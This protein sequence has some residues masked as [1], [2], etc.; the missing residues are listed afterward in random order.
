MIGFILKRLLVMKQKGGAITHSEIGKL[1]DDAK[2]IYYSEFQIFD[3]VNKE[4]KVLGQHLENV[5]RILNQQELLEV[6]GDLSFFD[7]S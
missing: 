4:L 1:A 6:E 5:T 3:K 2:A 7:L